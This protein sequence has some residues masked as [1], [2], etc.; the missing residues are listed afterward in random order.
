[1]CVSERS[2]VVG[3]WWVAKDG[4]RLKAGPVRGPGEERMLEAGQSP[5]MEGE[6]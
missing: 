4:K 3:R 6:Q 5:G 1:M 2:R